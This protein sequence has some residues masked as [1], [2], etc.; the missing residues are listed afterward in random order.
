MPRHLAIGDIHGCFDAFYGLCEFVK[1]R[2]DDVIVTLGD[3]CDRGPDTKG[4][5]DWLL[6]LEHFHALKPLR[7][8]HELMMLAARENPKD[9]GHWLKVGGRATLESYGE[10][11]DHGE[12][13]LDNVPD[14]HWRFLAQGL[15][16]YYE[17]ET[18]LFVHASAYCDMEL[19]EQPDYMLYWER[20]D[21]PPRH[22]SGKQLICGHAR[23]T[24]GLP[25]TNGNA[26]CIDTW[27]CG[28]G[29]LTCLHAESGEIWQCN[30]QGQ[31][32]RMFLNDIR[33]NEPDK[34]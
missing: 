25:V 6:K 29:W 7:G 9:L 2:P 15:L 22:Q 20:Y 14:N 26:V 11:H 1:L 19:N 3:Y 21:D 27:A 31:T 33:D 28:D 23:Q 34:Y 32:R 30:Q 10:S 12:P 13:S 24:S 8:N 5:I 17:S 16:P 4:V 18:H